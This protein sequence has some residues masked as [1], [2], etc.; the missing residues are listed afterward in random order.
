MKRS[1]IIGL[2]GRKGAGKS[3]IA[4]HM[5]GYGFAWRAFADPLKHIVRGF[6]TTRGFSTAEATRMLYGDMKA[7][8]QP[9]L[10]GHTPRHLMQTIG[11][12]WG[13][14]CIHPDIW[15]DLL[16][17]EIDALQAVRFVIDDVRFPNEV[18]A[19]RARGG[20][21]VWIERDGADLEDTHP[22]ENSI[23]ADDCDHGLVNN[24]STEEGFAEYGAQF[25]LTVTKE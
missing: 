19:I 7:V 24:L 12:E 10:W 5:M 15:V 16:M 23:T 6:L 22:S 3:T 2:A 21:V 25:I 1:Q 11:T 9:R 4:S 8:E 13:R 20:Q 18:E 14:R 17:S